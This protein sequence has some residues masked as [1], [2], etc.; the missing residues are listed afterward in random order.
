MLIKLSTGSSENGALLAR[1][2]PYGSLTWKGNTFVVGSENSHQFD[3][4]VVMHGSGIPE[5]QE[6][7]CD[8]AHKV[9][10]SMEPSVWGRPSDF[11]KQFNLVV[12]V[13]S[14]IIGPELINLNGHTWWSGINVRFDG[15][16][17]FERSDCRNLD[18]IMN[19]IAP[20]KTK[21]FSVI[22]SNKS[23]FPGHK[24]RLRFIEKLKSHPL[25]KYVDF[26]GFG[27]D[28]ISDKAT[29][30]RDYRYHICI[31]NSVEKNYWTEKIADPYLNFCYPIY[32]GCPNIFDFFDEGSLATFDIDRWELFPVILERILDEDRYND[33][34]DAI[35]RSRSRI[36]VDYNIFN[37]ISEICNKPA[38]ASARCSLY[39]MSYFKKDS[40]V[41]SRT[42]HML[43]RNFVLK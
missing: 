2:T 7:W 14:S 37:I 33:A 20:T 10:I 8:P 38:S 27:G 23:D 30:L 36:L 35:I 11:F 13:D 12:S 32:S 24:R 1:Q 9:L 42:R 15:R 26:Y 28:S 5:Q 34:L 29:G 31:E 43:R 39:P 18:Q 17:H 3:W 4:W 22:S 41:L 25:S 16:H 6:A 19:E 21:Y 40:G